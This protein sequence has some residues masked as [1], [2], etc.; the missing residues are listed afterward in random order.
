MTN[1]L[2]QDTSTADV[3]YKGFANESKYP[4]YIVIID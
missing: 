3:I 2:S 1:C 4:P